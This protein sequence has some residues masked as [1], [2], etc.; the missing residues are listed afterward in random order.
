MEIRCVGGGAIVLLNTDAEIV[1]GKLILGNRHVTATQ[2]Q[3]E[4]DRD[5]LG[6]GCD[7]LEVFARVMFQDSSSG[8]L[9]LDPIVKTITSN[10]SA[11]SD[12]PFN[13]RQ[14]SDTL[15]IRSKTGDWSG[16]RGSSS[17]PGVLGIVTTRSMLDAHDVEAWLPRLT[18]F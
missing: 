11:S 6:S 2:T 13:E 8:R 10:T 18:G 1:K 3:N 12:E 5:C 17:W 9:L 15:L 16:P 7:Q 14:P 4:R